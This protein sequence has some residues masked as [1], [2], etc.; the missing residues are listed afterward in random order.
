MAVGRIQADNKSSKM[1]WSAG[2]NVIREN[3]YI[4]SQFSKLDKNRERQIYRLIRFIN[5]IDTP[6]SVSRKKVKQL[7]HYGP[8]YSYYNQFIN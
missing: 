3:N 5:K 1:C 7:K 6:F 8:K 2:F 4:K